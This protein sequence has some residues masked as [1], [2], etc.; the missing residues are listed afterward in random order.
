MKKL[1]V[2]INNN[3]G[4]FPFGLKR[5]YNHHKEFEKDCLLA[6]NE[7]KDVQ[8]LAIELADEIYRYLISNNYSFNKKLDNVGLFDYLIQKKLS[9]PL[10]K[11]YHKCLNSIAIKLRNE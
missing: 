1:L 5:E 8:L 3:Y 7:A 9:E 10:S 2:A 11:S 6:G 4:G